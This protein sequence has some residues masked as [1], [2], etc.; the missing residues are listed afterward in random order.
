[1]GVSLADGF[2]D[3]LFARGLGGQRNESV[4]RRVAAHDRREMRLDDLRRVFESGIEKFR[5]AGKNLYALP[6][7]LVVGEPGSGKTEVYFEAIAADEMAAIAALNVL[8]DQR[9][10]VAG[11]EAACRSAARCFAIPRGLISR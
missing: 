5:A 4:D 9:S 11:T 10:H 8:L 2:G 3:G 1:M 7:Y 6:W